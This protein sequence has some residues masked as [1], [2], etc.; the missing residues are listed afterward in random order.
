MEQWFACLIHKQS[1]HGSSP[2]AKS[3]TNEMGHTDESY[4][5]GTLSM[6]IYI[7]IDMH[8]YSFYHVISCIHLSI[9]STIMYLSVCIKYNHVSI[10]LYQVLSVYLYQILLCIY[11]SV[12]SIIMYLSVYIEYY[13]VYICLIKYNHVCICLYQE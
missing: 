8:K 12:S 7:Y 6:E 5:D 4:E 3:K 1:I 10:C 11:L 2:T 9:S 13:H